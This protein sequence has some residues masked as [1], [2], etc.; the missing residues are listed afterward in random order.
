MTMTTNPIPGGLPEQEVEFERYELR[1]RPA[2]HFEFD[3]RD[4]AK[5]IGSGIAVLLISKGVV[6]QQESGQGRGGGQ[7]LPRD[8]S[9][10]LH[11][12]EDGAITVYTGKVEIGQNIR[13][14][15]AQVVAEE[16]HAPFEA[17][18][19]VMGDT[20]FTPYDQGTFG[21]QTTPRMGMQLR[22]V[23]SA[24]CDIMRDLAAKQWNVE[25]GRLVA[26]NG[27]ITDPQT[28]KSLS[29]GQLAQG[30]ALARAIPD[31]DPLI[32]PAEWTV[33]GKP[34][35]KVDG[36]DFV[37]G[38]HK[39]TSD[40]KLPGMMHGKVLRPPTFG[41]TLTSV[42]GSAAQSMPGVTFVH[43]GDFVGIAGTDP[44]TADRALAAIKA[45][46]KPAP[47]KTNS[48]EVYDYLKANPQA[49]GRGGGGG[50]GGQQ[51]DNSHAVEEALSASQHKLE[52]TYRVAYIAHAPLEPRAAVAQW[53]DGGL[54]V[55]TGTQRPFG[56]RSELAAAF[57]LSE[58]KVRVQMPDMGSGYGGKHTGECAVEA[59]RLAKAAGKPV[60]L[61]WTREEEFTWAY[62]RPAG[63]IEIRSGMSGD[64]TITAWEFLNYNSGPSAIETPYAVANRNVAFHPTDYPLRQGSYRGLAGTA[65]VFA[66]E[67]H[68]DDLAEAVKMDPLAFRL[69][70]LPNDP[71]GDRLRGVLQA[72]A[73]K[74][75]WSKSQPAPDHGFGI[76]CGV[77]KGGHIAACAEVAVDRATGAVKIVR[78]VA[79][80]DCGA[81]VNPD[82]LRNQVMGANIQGLGG[83]LFESIE[84][85][86]GAITNPK[87]S[88]YR[89]PRFPDMPNIEVVLVDRKDIQPAGAGE[90]PLMALAPA[91]GNAIF[92]ATK[93]RLRALPLAPNGIKA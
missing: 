50:R 68:M 42:D 41:A 86:N 47:V 31:T 74:F 43:D 54:N 52:A 13:T 55:W 66:R 16:L 49:G 21:S 17:I 79:A 15:L 85:E 12:A 9:A 39:Y 35:A 64:G 71:T 72:A 25:A 63:V 24:A 70:N 36:R 53:E 11:I 58:D 4:F 73:E 8:I 6:A 26:A 90:T 78:V 3:R 89:V 23:A 37:T 33:A 91:I 7:S 84:F 48:R 19:M 61:V 2:H 14:S 83:A 67:S 75:G 81:I 62:F 51:A 69:K 27:A 10:W 80:F 82:G 87:F 92:H 56:V 30:Q 38:R 88:K 18:R 40:V 34:L 44:Q 76:A 32:P 1:E 77:E 46:W 60:K 45:E 20:K 22:R 28:K 65:N 59:A 93:I 29:Y 5:I 57:H